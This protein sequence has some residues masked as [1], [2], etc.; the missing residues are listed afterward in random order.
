MDIWER[1]LHAGLVGDDE[2]EGGFQGGQGR[3]CRRLVV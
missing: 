2:A 3:L 1:G